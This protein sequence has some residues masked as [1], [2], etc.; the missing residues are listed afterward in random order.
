MLLV[1]KKDDELR[2]CI[3]YWGLNV[4]TQQ[5]YY[6]LPQIDTCHDLLD[7]NMQFSSLDM[8]SSYWQVPIKEWT[9]TRPAL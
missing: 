6:S 5:V 2:Y 9:S 4:T 7:R 3:S 8:H 1:K